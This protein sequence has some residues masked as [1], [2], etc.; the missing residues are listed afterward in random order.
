MV[1]LGRFELPT[2]R[3]SSARSNQL[4]YRPAGA[5][6]RA[7]PKRHAIGADARGHQQRRTDSVYPC[8]ER[9]TKTAEIPRCIS[10][11]K[12]RLIFDPLSNERFEAHQPEG[13]FA[14]R[15]SSLERR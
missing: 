13:R 7:H 5:D 8:E 12:D 10:K 1:G 15:S 11:I 4:S 14:W 6:A 2:S 9:E 3:L